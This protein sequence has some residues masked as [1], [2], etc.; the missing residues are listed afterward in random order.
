MAWCTVLKL[1]PDASY[2]SPGDYLKWLM[3]A[4]THRAWERG[5]ESERESR[6]RESTEMA[7]GW[8]M[9]RWL[10][11]EF[12]PPLSI[13]RWPELVSSYFSPRWS[14]RGFR[15]PDLD[16]SVVDSVLWSLVTAFESVALISMLCFFFLF[17]GCT[18]WSLSRSSSTT[19]RKL[20][21]AGFTPAAGILGGVSNA[22]DH[23]DW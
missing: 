20:T 3:A 23:E 18:V 7:W 14:S 4:K 22:V 11:L 12:T 13:F 6:E 19:F 21:N 9:L 5:R 1:G 8:S 17:C 15:W 10:E 2:N 16:F